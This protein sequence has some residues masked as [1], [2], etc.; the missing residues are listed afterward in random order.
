MRILVMSDSHGR[1]ENMIRCVEQVEPQHVLFLGDGLS[2]FAALRRRFPDLPMD[3]VPG[4][5]DWS[6]TEEPERF[7]ELGGKR[8]LMLHGHTRGVKYSL[9]NANYAARELGADV[10]LY[11]HTHCPMVDFDGTLYVMNPGSIGDRHAPSY[12][13]ITINR[14]TFDCSTYR[15]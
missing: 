4:N 7:I 6:S 9:M 8:I 3:A 12:G 15:L 10:L 1:G 14:E 2:D 11:G 5:C 13:I